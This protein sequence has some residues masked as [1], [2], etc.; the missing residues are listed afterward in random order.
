MTRAKGLLPE[1]EG[2]QIIRCLSPV[3][4]AIHKVVGLCDV[5]GGHMDS[6][7]VSS[8]RWV[9]LEP[10]AGVLGRSLSSHSAPLIVPISTHKNNGS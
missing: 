7:L 2:I 10:S 4:K 9:R 1:V 5:R 3:P 8:D 6:G